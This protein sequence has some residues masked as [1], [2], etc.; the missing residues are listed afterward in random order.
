MTRIADLEVILGDTGPFC[1]LAEA[2]EAHLD[3]A[4]GY[5]KARLQIVMDVH[6]ELRRRATT[7]AHGRLN[8]LALLGIPEHEPITITDKFLLE[9]VDTLVE[10]RRR[11]KPGHA[12]E[13]RGEVATALVAAAMSVSGP[14]GRWLGQA[15]GRQSE[16]SGF[17]DAGPGGGVGGDGDTSTAIR[18]RDLQGRLRRCSAGRVRPS[19]RAV[20]GPAPLSHRY[21]ARSS[22]AS[23]IPSASEPSSSRSARTSPARR[24]WLP[25]SVEADTLSSDPRIESSSTATRSIWS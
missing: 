18:L 12:D 21:V 6:R 13:D 20:S 22:K 19:C 4:A 16:R 7:P 11:R 1:R 3:V 5:L 25:T 24:C 10:G 9:R 23:L 2:G 14:D 8:R 15:P 17:H